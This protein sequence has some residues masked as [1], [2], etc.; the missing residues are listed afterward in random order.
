MIRYR[1]LAVLLGAVVLAACE[2]NGVLVLGGPTAG[3]S[4]KFYNFGLNDPS[5]NFYANDV[6]VTVIASTSCTPPVDSTCFTTGIE[7]TAGTAYGAVGNGGLYSSLAPAQYTFAAKVAAGADKGLGISSLQTTLAD[8]KS[9][10]LYLS[11]PY[12]AATKQVSSFIVEDPIPT[13]ID[14][15]TA[16]VRFVNAIS[17]SNPMTL[18]AKSTV[19]GDSVVVGSNI[20]YQSASAF[21]PM[22][23]VPYDLT[24]RYAGSNT[25]VIVRA[26]VQFVAGRVYTVSSRG[27]MTVTS[28]TAANRPQLDNTANR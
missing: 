7:A 20:A 16:Y 1:I 14:P 23:G 12:N 11:G 3:S 13:T 27:D 6:K 19:T 26:G 2:K 21:L 8:G 10:S 9:Y 18:Y 24:V 15:A 28:S 25:G 4:V 5:V 22:A 17:N